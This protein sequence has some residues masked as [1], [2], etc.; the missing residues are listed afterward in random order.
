[1]SRAKIPA[2]IIG[3][4]LGAGKTTLINAF[5]QDPGG[6]RATVL[7]NDFGAINIDADLIENAHGDTISLTNGCACCSIGDSLLEAALSVAN[8][9][10]PPDLI[11]VEASGVSHPRRIAN[12]L[13][14][15]ADLAPATCLTVVNGARV[16]RNARDK[17]IARLFA[18]QIASADFLSLNRFDQA[19]ML[20]LQETYRHLPQPVSISDLIA[21]RAHS[22]TQGA[23]TQAPPE[24]ASDYQSITICVPNPVSPE[25]LKAWLDGLPEGVERLKGFVLM[26]IGAGAV[27]TRFL[28]YVQ[29]LYDLTPANPEQSA[30][31]GSI[32][33]IFHSATEAGIGVPEIGV[34]E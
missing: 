28:S 12:T 6:L 17:Y 19:G 31:P 21:G 32:V 29:G 18:A 5:L 1:M 20:F 16:Q 34:P 2:I 15:V 4:Y 26:D 10:I 23:A 7:V 25:N 13:M 27:E 14:G 33:A 8:V 30:N 3:G 24:T 11:L 22:G 9:A